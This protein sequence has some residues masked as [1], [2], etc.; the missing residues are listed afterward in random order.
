MWAKK[1]QFEY[2]RNT[3]TGSEHVAR[4]GADGKSKGCRH[5]ATLA[6][7][8]SVSPS[9]TVT[10]STKCFETTSKENF[11][12]RRFSALAKFIPEIFSPSCLV[13][14]CLS[15]LSSLPLV[16]CLP[17]SGVYRLMMLLN[18]AQNGASGNESHCPHRGLHW[19]EG[20]P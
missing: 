12:K 6:G 7:K 14:N 11:K 10:L 9:D 3:K 15:R 16:G 8:P 4:Q 19:C 2:T 17:R 5:G 18:L 13:R 1:D 20:L